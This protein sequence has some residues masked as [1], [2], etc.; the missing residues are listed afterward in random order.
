MSQLIRIA[1]RKEFASKDLWE[2]HRL[3]AKV[4]NDRMG[5]EIPIMSGMEIDGYDAL[6]P[7]YLMV[8]KSETGLS[9]CMRVLPTEGPYMLKDTFPEL[10]HGQLAPTDPKIW[11]LSRFAIEVDDVHG[12]G[13]SDLTMDVTRAIVAFGDKMGI[14]RFVTVTTTAIERMMRRAGLAVSRYGPPIRIG[15]ENAVALDFD[16]GEQTHAALFGKIR[17]AA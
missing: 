5:W 15:V 10:L 16:I 11:E 8:R 13:F 9:G 3:R 1:S 7:Y 12:F 14:E 2:M 6:D 4:F 17:Q